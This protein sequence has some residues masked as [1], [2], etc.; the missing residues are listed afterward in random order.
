MT[1]RFI[2]W[3]YGLILVIAALLLAL[4]CRQ[5][6][7]ATPLVALLEAH[8]GA[9]GTPHVLPECGCTV[10]YLGTTV[11]GQDYFVHLRRLD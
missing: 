8:Y 5:A 10:R 2:T 9:P 7:A 3:G 11:K 1:M 6:L 4:V